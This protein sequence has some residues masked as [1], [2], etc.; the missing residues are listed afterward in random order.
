MYECKK[1]TFVQIKLCKQIWK[2]FKYIYRRAFAFALLN[3]KL[4]FA[5]FL[6][7][8]LLWF[9]KFTFYGSLYLKIYEIIL[10]KG[11]TQNMTYK[12]VKYMNKVKKLAIN[13]HDMTSRA[14]LKKIKVRNLSKSL[15]AVYL[16]ISYFSVLYPSQK[17]NCYPKIKFAS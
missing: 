4:I 1:N 10:C 11:W 16:G 17:K 13:M 15:I 7:K 2:F 9:S 5:L 12:M 3:I 8:S 6:N 14:W